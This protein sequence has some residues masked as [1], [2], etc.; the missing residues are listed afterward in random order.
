[1]SYAPD[2]ERQIAEQLA[3]PPPGMVSQGVIMVVVN[4]RCRPLVVWNWP[5]PSSITFNDMSNTVSLGNT[6]SLCGE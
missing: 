6:H 5:P 2:E 4:E 3:N 1:M